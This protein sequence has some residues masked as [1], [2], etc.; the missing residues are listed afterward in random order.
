MAEIV[1]SNESIDA[2]MDEEL[3]LDYEEDGEFHLISATAAFMKRD[4]KRIVG[5][6][7]VVVPSYQIALSIDQNYLRS[8]CSRVGSYRRNLHRKSFWQKTNSITEA[9]F[10]I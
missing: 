3:I 4:L 5:F 10:G 9:D 2:S 6:C 1:I 7:E 8:S